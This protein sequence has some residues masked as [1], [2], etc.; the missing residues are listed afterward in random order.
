VTATATHGAEEEDGQFLHRLIAMV[1]TIRVLIADDH[2][3]I[4]EGLRACL[5]NTPGIELVGEARDGTEAQH[6]CGQLRPAVLLLDLRMPGPTAFETVTYLHANYPQVRVVIFTAYDD[7]ASV[8]AML[9]VGVAG[10]L[11]K[12]EAF[13]VVARAIRIVHQGGTWFSPSVLTALAND[14]R[15]LPLEHRSKL[16]ERE[17]EVLQ[18]VV[19]NKTNG[20][21]AATLMLSE[22]T[23]EK[24]L[25]RV[26]QKLGVTTRLAAALHARDLG[27][28]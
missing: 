14:D 9:A 17:L 1:D 25:K 12:D 5:A 24:H 7:E 2:P 13:L 18:L 26:F 3:L 19:A 10:Y 23:V 16:T 4:R 21:I 8:R 6:L 11:L 22:K 20:E 27:L 28:V 15:T